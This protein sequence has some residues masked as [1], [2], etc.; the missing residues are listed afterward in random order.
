VQC[1]SIVVTFVSLDG[2]L[3]LCALFGALHSDKKSSAEA[4]A[5]GL[6]PAFP[7]T[8]GHWEKS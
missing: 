2:Y 4:P 5:L 3:E 8:G 7:L 1:R 6:L